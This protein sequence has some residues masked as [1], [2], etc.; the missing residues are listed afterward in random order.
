LLAWLVLGMVFL[1]QNVGRRL[2]LGD[3]R[4]WQ[5]VP[6]W[7]VSIAMFAL[8]TPLI[9]WCGNRFPLDKSNWLR[10]ALLH[11]LL[12]LGIGLLKALSASIVYYAF[13]I[14]YAPGPIFE[15]D[16]ELALQIIYGIHVSTIAYWMII[17]IQLVHRNYIRYQ[18]RAKEALRLQLNSAQLHAQI[19]NARLNALK[20]QLQPHFLFNTLNAIIVLVRQQRV[21]LAEATLERLSN[22]LRVVLT[23]IEAQEVPLSR[24]LEY[25]DLYLSIEQLRFSDRLGIS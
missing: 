16:K 11:V 5:D 9:L 20:A 10:P 24:E 1:G 7:A 18:E 25:I 13:P 17:G 4:P 19:T 3:V 15:F 23:D 8:L 2:Y 14:L 6:Y 21:T 12:G 22:L